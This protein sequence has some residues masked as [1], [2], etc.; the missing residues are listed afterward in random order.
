ME[1]RAD[2]GALRLT[3]PPEHRRRLGHRAG[4]NLA[5]CLVSR[6][7]RERCATI[8][9]ELLGFKHGDLLRGKSRLEAPSLQQ[10]ASCVQCIY[11]SMNHANDALIW[12]FAS[13]AHSSSLRKPEAS[14]PLINS[15]A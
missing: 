6:V 12:I 7:R 8:G 1:E 14:P 10:L 5:N 4:K 13:C 2:F 15:C 3:E 9:D 11:H